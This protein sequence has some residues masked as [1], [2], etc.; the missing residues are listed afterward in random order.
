MKS[1]RIERE[2]RGVV[3]WAVMS[4]GG[5]AQR[6]LWMGT[7]AWVGVGVGVMRVLMWA[8]LGRRRRE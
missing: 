7:E 5:D 3:W 2:M 6:G 1:G 4:G 8:V